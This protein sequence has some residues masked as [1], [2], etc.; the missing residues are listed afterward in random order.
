MAKDRTVYRVQPDPDG[1]WKLSK[2]EKRVERFPQQ[3]AAVDRGREMA[4]A[5][6]PSQLVV[7][8]TDGEIEAESTYQDDPFPP[9]G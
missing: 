5:D 4:K 6:Q 9:R 7:H 3:R 1:A 2:N 8:G